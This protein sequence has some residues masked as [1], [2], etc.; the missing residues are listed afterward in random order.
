MEL[1]LDAIATIFI[2]MIGLPAILLQTLPAEIRR[3]VLQERKQ[4]VAFFTIGPIVLASAMVAVGM[5]LTAPAG[6]GESE[7]AAMARAELIWLGLVAALL[8]ISGA[9]AL[10]FTER[11]RRASVVNHLHWA[12]ARG[13]PSRGRPIEEVLRTLVDLGIQSQAGQDKGLVIDALARLTRQT[14]A[15]EGY[16]GAQLE[17]VITGLEDIFTAGAHVGSANNFLASAELLLELIMDG[18]DRTHS[19]DLKA[20]V[21]AV[22]LLGRGSLA[23]EQSHI[24]IKF[25]DALGWAGD[26]GGASWASQAMFE[27]GGEAFES[28]NILVAMTALSKLETLVMRYSPV[29]GE[30][31]SDFI[32]LMAHCWGRGE[33]GRMYCQRFLESAGEFFAD[34]LP[35]V[36]RKAREECMNKARF[37]TGNHLARMLSAL[38]PAPM[39]S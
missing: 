35:E 7:E 36:I 33:T 15:C 29:G 4:E 26:A 37:T 20:A 34:P 18:G 14:Q 5:G 25:L 24:Q 27:I 28:N 9:S 1:P 6:G 3:T 22:S 21:Q 16:D 30:I 38:G 8:V 12:A 39:T 11:W 13:I 23:H 19:D 10:L 2:F 31:A 17:D 32:G